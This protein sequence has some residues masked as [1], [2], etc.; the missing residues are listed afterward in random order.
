MKS[1]R[2]IAGAVAI[3]LTAAQSAGANLKDEKDQTRQSLVTLGPCALPTAEITS[4]LPWFIRASDV[5]CM[6]V[7]ADDLRASERVN[8]LLIEVGARLQNESSFSRVKVEYDRGM[9][10]Y[11]EGNYAEAIA[12]LQAADSQAN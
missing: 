12:H 6:S 4:R 9:A 11:G 3:F 10:A 2:L 8:L 1:T 7:T 5:I